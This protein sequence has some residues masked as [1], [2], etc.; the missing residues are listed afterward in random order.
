MS[1][2]NTWITLPIEL[3][4]ISNMDIWGKKLSELQSSV[5][6][7]IF[8]TLIKFEPKSDLYPDSNVGMCID[9]WLN[10][11]DFTI[12]FW[13]NQFCSMEK[14]WSILQQARLALS[15]DGLPLAFISSDSAYQVLPDWWPVVYA[16]HHAYPNTIL[17]IPRA[18]AN[19]ILNDYIDYIRF[20]L[21]S[22]EV[23]LGDT[24]LIEISE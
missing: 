12:T 7:L 14:F 24:S 11:W 9:Q 3:S 18:L 21:E 4:W 13:D 16:F 17:I 8:W 20:I 1:E 15:S 10:P 22:E 23:G 5:S 2:V 6:S 19:D